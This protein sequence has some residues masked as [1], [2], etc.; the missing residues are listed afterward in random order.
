MSLQI[1][2]AVTVA[3]RR[4]GPSIT[5]AFHVPVPTKTLFLI[6]QFYDSSID[7]IS[8]FCR[9][10]NSPLQYIQPWQL[11][12]SSPTALVCLP[13]CSSLRF[14]HVLT[15]YRCPQTRPLARTIQG[16]PQ[17]SIRLRPGLDQQNQ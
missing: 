10:I 2:G 4:P 8:C 5:L 6:Y 12:Q 15:T 13:R 14:L 17:D 16:R 7:L 9:S 11:L 3:P 1:S